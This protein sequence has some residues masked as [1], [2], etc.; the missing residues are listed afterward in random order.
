VTF[1][2]LK[3]GKYQPSPHLTPTINF[4]KTLGTQRIK[5]P[6]ITFHAKLEIYYFEESHYSVPKE[7]YIIFIDTD[8]TIYNFQIHGFHTWHQIF[9]IGRKTL[10]RRKSI[11]EN[12]ITQHQFL[13]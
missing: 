1:E 12:G 9:Q 10:N 6:C 7:K 8:D 5:L 3:M 2:K 11:H 4:F 13:L